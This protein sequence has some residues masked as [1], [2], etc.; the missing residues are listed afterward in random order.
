ME[1]KS[2]NQI[3]K[4]QGHNMSVEI[5]SQERQ[6]LS[7][8]IKSKILKA[9]FK[10]RRQWKKDGQ[11][12]ENLEGDFTLVVCEKI[13][14]GTPEDMISIPIEAEGDDGGYLHVY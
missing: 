9:F 4:S 7:Q 11:P 3:P 5:I 1:N 10:E 13:C 12:K 2:I 8:E 6:K 14:L